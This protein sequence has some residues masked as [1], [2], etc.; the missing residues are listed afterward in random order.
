MT[1]FRTS[2]AALCVAAALAACSDQP[3]APSIDAP[4]AA[5]AR[6]GGSSTTCAASPDFLVSDDAGLRAAVGA[7]QS[8]DVIA[9]AGTIVLTEPVWV[10]TDGLTLT[11]GSAGAG[12]T[13]SDPGAVWAMIGVTAADL[14]VS[15]LTIDAQA[16]GYPVYALNNGMQW[17]GSRLVFTGNDVRCGWACMFLVGTD[18][19]RIADNHFEAAFAGTGIHLQRFVRPDGVTFG[20]DGSRIER[21]RVVALQPTGNPVFGA[22]R[23]RDGAGIVIADN[24]IEGPWSNGIGVAEMSGA[25]VERNRVSG[26]TQFG[27]FISSNPFEPV[28]TSG[29]VFLANHLSG[30]SAAIFAR[31]ACDN[32]ITGNVLASAGAWAVVFDATTGS[33]AFMGRGTSVLDDGSLDCDGDGIADPNAIT[34]AGRRGSGGSGIGGIVSA[35]IP[36]VMGQGMM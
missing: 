24:V 6:G 4:P 18:A 12:L 33:N 3:I 8:G 20:T 28:S 7:A 5:L 23:P 19:A 35:V 27:L 9:I 22:I 36:S 1:R 32:V 29:S 10:E 25:R 15:G 16:G 17:T 31:R 26:A 21:N 2:L 34:G 14:T 30:G 11:C 13:H